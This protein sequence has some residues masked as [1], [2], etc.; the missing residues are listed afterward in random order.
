MDRDG[1]IRLEV[2]FTGNLKLNGSDPIRTGVCA[3]L[4]KF[5]KRM[6]T[7]EPCG[8]PLD[9]NEKYAAL[10]YACAYMTPGTT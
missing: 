3:S 4:E 1:F 5:F 9:Y 7:F 10:K 6:E 2:L 8:F